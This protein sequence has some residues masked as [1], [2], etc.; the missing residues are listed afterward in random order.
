MGALP[1]SKFQCVNHLRRFRR[2]LHAK[3]TRLGDKRTSGIVTDYEVF[4][5]FMINEGVANN[6]MSTSVT[7]TNKNSNF[8][9]VQ[10]GLLVVNLT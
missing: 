9:M 3:I 4:D 5:K 7:L 8:K 6:V 2:S 1:H 10:Y